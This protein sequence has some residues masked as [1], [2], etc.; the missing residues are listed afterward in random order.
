MKLNLTIQ[1]GCFVQEAVQKLKHTQFIEVMHNTQ[2]YAKYSYLRNRKRV[3][4]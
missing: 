2:Q 4:Q 1:T 3:K